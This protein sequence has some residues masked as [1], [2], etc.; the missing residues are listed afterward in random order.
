[1]AQPNDPGGEARR[2]SRLAAELVEARGTRAELEGAR[3]RLT[4]LEA[5]RAG[6]GGPG[7]APARADLGLAGT[8]PGSWRRRSRPL[9]PGPAR[10][11]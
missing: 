9:C 1:V 2:R 3:A 8:V 4:A 7:A 11:G 6:G 5:M 10:L